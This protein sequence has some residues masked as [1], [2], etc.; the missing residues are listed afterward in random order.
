MEMIILITVNVLKKI[1][2]V[3]LC[4]IYL[5][6]LTFINYHQGLSALADY[7]FKRLNSFDLYYFK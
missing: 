6:Q 1:K 7:L 2:V 5:K 4:K 3:L